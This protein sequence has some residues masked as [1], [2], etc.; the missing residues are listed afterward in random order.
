MAFH[1]RAKASRNIAIQDLTMVDQ[2]EGRSF[3]HPDASPAWGRGY[4]EVGTNYGRPL[5]LAMREEE[6]TPG[7]PATVRCADS[8][9]PDC[10]ARKKTMIGYGQEDGSRRRTPEKEYEKS[11]GR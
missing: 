7:N 9:R 1:G 11:E 4:Q 2:M 8:R 6:E 10:D 5:C 3:I